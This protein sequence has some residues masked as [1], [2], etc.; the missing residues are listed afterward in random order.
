M[1]VVV[2]NEGVTMLERSFITPGVE[3][4]LPDR[5]VLTEQMT[6]RLTCLYYM[7]ILIKIIT[8]N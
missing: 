8:I 3:L 1:S 7:A 4:S 2:E 6:S 5:Q